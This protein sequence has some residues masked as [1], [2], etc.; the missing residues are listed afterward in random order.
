MKYILIALIFLT[1]AGCANRLQ[2]PDSKSGFLKNYHLFKPN[3]NTDDSWIRTK[4]F[5]K[6][7]ELSQYKKIAL[8][9][10]EIWLN[11]NEPANITDKDKQKRLTDYFQQQIKKTVGDRFEFVEPGTKDSLLIRIALTNIKELEPE[12]SPLDVIPFRIVMN[13]GKQVYLLAA[14]KKA[15]I[16]AAT[17]EVEFVDTN[18]SKGLVA[19]IVNS[20]TDE[21][22][23]DDDDVNID[24][25]K[26][27]IDQWVERLTGALRPRED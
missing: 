3:P 19:V 11:P 27:V 23:V 25:V 13:A 4:R 24:S 8:N 9:P 26:L 12:L 16:G 22:N 5:F 20:K 17:L 10:I 2:R 1:I 14:A 6:V 15:V 18:T 21:V 7:S